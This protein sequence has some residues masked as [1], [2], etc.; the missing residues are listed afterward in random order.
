MR[1]ISRGATV[2]AALSLTLSSESAA[3][4]RAVAGFEAVARPSTPRPVPAPPQQQPPAT[5]TGPDFALYG[6]LAT[7]DDPY[8]LGFIV[9][10]SARWQ[11]ANVPVTFRGDVSFSRHS[12]D[13]DFGPFGDYDLNL[14]L[15]GAMALVEYVFA[16]TG[17]LRPY[18]FGGLGLFYANVDSDFDS[19]FGSDDD[20][21]SSTDLGFGI[22]AGLNFT[23]RI[24]AE[25][26]F[27]DVGGFTT[28][29]FTIV[30]RF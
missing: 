17:Q 22:G 19:G 1:W 29:P 13:V 7:G 15:F 3:Q 12:G 28:I 10:A 20:Y 4:K 18:V 8:D 24:G 23:E 14:N 26:R 5:N 27:M 6:G 16:T 21:D 11:R 2:A 9:G 25:F 30:I